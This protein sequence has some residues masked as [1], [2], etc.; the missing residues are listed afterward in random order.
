MNIWKSRR[1]PYKECELSSGF[2]KIFS[3]CLSR[4]HNSLWEIF[5]KLAYFCLHGVTDLFWRLISCL[6]R[7]PEV[8]P[9]FFELVSK[10]WHGNPSEL[11]N[12]RVGRR[13]HLKAQLLLAS[14]FPKNWGY[15]GDI[16]SHILGSVSSPKRF[17]NGP[18]SWCRMAWIEFDKNLLEPTRY[19]PFSF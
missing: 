10:A 14:H 12:I 2:L 1:C 5:A 9:I 16:L 18:R 13:G 11:K 19:L 17:I 6:R 15:Q 4:P 7:L 3:P 8:G